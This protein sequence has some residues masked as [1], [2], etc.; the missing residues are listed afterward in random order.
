MRN[1]FAIALSL[2]LLASSSAIAHDTLR[3]KWCPA[4]TTVV[5]V[6]TFDLT[7]SAQVNYRT[8]HLSDG[9]VLGSECNDMK[10]AAS[11]TTGSGPTKPPIKPAPASSLKNGQST[12]AMPLISHHAALP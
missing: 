12:P 1:G 2:G 6:G 3:A 7:P 10:P 4:G 9:Q 5:T 11:S 8:Q